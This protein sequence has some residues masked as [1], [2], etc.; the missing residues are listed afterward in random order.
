MDKHKRVLIISYYFAPQNTMGAVRPTK[1]AKYL[2]RMG[3]EVT[4]ICGTGMDNRQDPTLARDMAEMKDVRVLDAFNPLKRL[5][6]RRATARS[7]S[8][9]ALN[10]PAPPPKAEAASKA[11]L[12]QRIAN[13]LYLFLWVV[14]DRCFERRGKQELKKL[15]GVYDAVFSSYAPMSCHEIAYAAVS[16]GLAKRWVADFRD[17]MGVS[18]GWQEPRKRRLWRRLERADALTAVSQGT[19]EAMGV[20]QRGQVLFNGFDRDDAVTAVLPPKDDVF[21]AVYCGQFHM[22][23]KGVGDRDLT[24]IFAAFQRLIAQGELSK[25]ELRLC[26]AG[27]EGD[28]FTRYADSCGLGDCVQL[29]GSVSREASLRLQAQADLLLMAS[30]NLSGQTG[31]L[32]GKLFEY[33]MIG[34]PIACYMSGDAAGSELKALLAKTG[35]GVCAEEA[36]GK[37]DLQRL[38]DHLRTVIRRWR[39][40]EPPLPPRSA[41]EASAFD[42]RRLAQTL[43]GLLGLNERGECTDE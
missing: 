12:K 40:G 17:E 22:G 30:W 15:D 3:H 6:Q 26:Y 41:D 34:K 4:V 18:F 13:G 1:L 9:A 19:L 11:G 25:A 2:Q 43:A 33:L 23:R 20:A 36:A 16:R 7:E 14:A 39:Q 32:T 10:A 38:E 29:Y 27:G 28:R 31:I 21:H 5:K 24:P 42:Y 35:A 8:A 37:E